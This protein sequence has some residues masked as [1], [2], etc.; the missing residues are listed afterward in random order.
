MNPEWNAHL[1]NHH[2]ASAADADCA[3]SALEDMAL[4][5]ITG[6]DARDFLQG[7]LTND[8]RR[9]TPDR[10]QLSAW[11]TAKGRMLAL[12]LV[13]EHGGELRLLLPRERRDVVLKRLGMF[14]LRA[15]VTLAA[16][17]DLVTAGLT[18][19]CMDDLAP[20]AP[21]TPFACDLR[22]G[23]TRIRLPGPRPRL[24][25]AGPTPAMIALHDAMAHRI[26]RVDP[27]FWHLEEIRAGLPQVY[28]AT[29]EAFVPQM[30]NLDRLDGVSFTKG[31]YTGQEVVARMRYLGQL[32]RRMYLA[33]MAPGTPCPPPGTP[34]HSTSSRS[35]QG[36]G[37][38][39]DARPTPE[40]GCEALVVAE[41]AAAEAGD[42]RIGNEK[43]PAV[44]LAPPP[45]GLADGEE[46]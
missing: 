42:L 30:C 26:I 11:C 40:G 8:I 33:R 20:D 25:L 39:V 12:F 17:D 32:K 2:A 7:Q 38:V 1:E 18:G 19:D 28:D 9:V 16:D 14:V 5:R 4:I 6:E 41:I 21:Q 37:R 45:Y 22:D 29:A 13:F 3:F 43:G 44:A 15:R 24:L 34:L 46:A 36:A 31:C 10:A 27:D 23:V 35:A